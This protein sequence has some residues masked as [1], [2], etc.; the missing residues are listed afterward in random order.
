MM[1]TPVETE[2]TF[3]NDVLINAVLYVPTGTKEEYEKV[4]PW[5]N[6]FNI[7]EFDVTGISQ[8]ETAEEL[9]VTVEGG[10]IVVD[11]AKGL[12]TVYDISGAMV[13]SGN[14]NGG[15]TEITVPGHGIYIVKIGNKAVKVNL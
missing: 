3:E 9:G 5:R 14:A 15:R 8:I 12:I 1:E 2:A 4:D 13:G 6:F 7:E 11:N 10:N